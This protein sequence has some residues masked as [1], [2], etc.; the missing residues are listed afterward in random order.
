M[1]TLRH[2]RARAIRKPLSAGSV[3]SGGHG[4]NRREG[5]D[6]RNVFKVMRRKAATLAQP[7]PDLVDEMIERYITWRKRRT[8]VREAYASW[9]AAASHDRDRAFHAYVAALDRE[10]WAA[11]RYERAVERSVAAPLTQRE[12]SSPAR[13][14]RTHPA[15]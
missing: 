5:F 14:G 15:A 8:A 10:Q 4:A 7:A 3:E 6:S 1:S 12:A 9:H 2:E 13:S 11:E